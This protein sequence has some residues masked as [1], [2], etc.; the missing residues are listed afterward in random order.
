MMISF[1]KRLAC[2]VVALSSLVAP[3]LCQDVPKEMKDKIDAAVVEAYRAVAASF[4]CKIKT[5]GKAH[6]LRW[7]GVDRCLNNAAGKVEWEALSK[8]LQSLRDSV[9]VISESSFAAEVDATLSAHALTFDKVFS[10]KDPKACL[11]LTNSLLKFL[12][13][14]SL[15]NLPVFNKTGMQVGIFSGVYISERTGGLATA[16]PYRLALFQYTDRNGNMQSPT[17]K[18]LLDSYGVPW[19]DAMS[20]RGF[21]LISEKL[22]PRR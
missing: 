10:V 9:Y 8:Q 22:F 13:A 3:A 11:T 5:G 16:N 12:P 15:Q 20:Q 1:L 21:R 17:D 19:R 18:L 14:D 2:T 7:E 6:M 4:P